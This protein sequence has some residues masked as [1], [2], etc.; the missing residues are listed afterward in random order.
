VAEGVAAFKLLFAERTI[1]AYSRTYTRSPLTALCCPTDEQ[2][3]VLV[4]DLIELHDIMGIAVRDEDQARSE[5]VRLELL[6]IPHATLTTLTF[7]VAPEF[8]NK[9]S[10]STA[11]KSGKRPV[12]MTFDKTAAQV[13]K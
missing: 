5:L 8:W 12:E 7:I 11:L 1:G 6:G 13:R 4:P 10:L 9:N 2:A 3:E